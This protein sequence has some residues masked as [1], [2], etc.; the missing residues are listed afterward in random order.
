MKNIETAV[1]GMLK[2]FKRYDI[3]VT[4]ATV[5]LLAMKNTEA[6]QTD[7]NNKTIPYK[8]TQFSPFPLTTNK[9]GSLDPD[10][11]LGNK[12]IA[13][14]LEHKNQEF[15]S[16]TYSHFYCC[17]NGISNQDFEL[18]CD[19]MLELSKKL[20]REFTSIV[21]PRNQ[22]SKAALTI[23]NKK[24]YTSYRGNQENRYW[25]NSQFENESFLK[26]M[27]RVLD[28]YYKISKTKT[29]KISEL[30]TVEGLLNIPA[31]RFFRPYSG[32]NWL[33]KRKIKRIKREMLKAARNETVYHLWWHPHNFTPYL[34]ESLGQL[35]ELLAYQLVL[36]KKYGFE[37]LNMSEISNRA[38]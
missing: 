8:N 1:I 4:W 19:R 23:L 32:K 28:A 2:L 25:K 13:A 26:R 20:N 12:E 22:I 3:H 29:F 24:N 6:L 15:A 33:E 36:K 16:H 27:M 34:Q 9:Y 31:N 11:L 38:K 5:G 35:E 7:K 18:D 37:S 21:F 30:E 10:L 17:E 14:I